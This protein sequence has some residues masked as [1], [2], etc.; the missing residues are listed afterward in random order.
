[1][2]QNLITVALGLTTVALAA[3]AI[4]FWQQILIWAEDSIHPWF[5]D[6][7]PTVAPYVKDAFANLDKVATPIRR[8]AKEAWVKI[9]KHLLKQVVQINRTS[10]N[11]W[12]QKTT[13]WIIKNL[14]ESE[15]SVI[16]HS[17]MREVEWPMLPDDVRA[18]YLRMRKTSTEIDITAI[19][20]KEIDELED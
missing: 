5:E 4:V 3:A 17:T 18:A 10:D 20:D 19:R 14:E 6:H 7:L 15:P 13:S 11:K 12:I 16:E 1:M 8:K 9:R 2:I